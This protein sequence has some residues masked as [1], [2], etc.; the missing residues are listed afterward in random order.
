MSGVWW[1]DVADLVQE[2]IEILDIP[3]DRSVLI[4]GPPGSGKTNLLLLR[5]NHLFIADQPN[6]NVVVFGSV[7]RKFIQLGNELYR[8]P[9]EKIVTHA[10]LFSDVLGDH[11]RHIDTTEMSLPD[12]RSAKAAALATLNSTGQLGKTYQAILLDEAQDYSSSEVEL[13]R[14]MAGSLVATCD[15]KQKI[16]PGDDSVPELGPVNT[17]EAHQRLGRS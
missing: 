13:F 9:S 12:A 8:F 7:L 4:K 5:A 2:Q 1:K 17:S 3:L 16:Y 6:I 11:G 15:S 10:R 14:A